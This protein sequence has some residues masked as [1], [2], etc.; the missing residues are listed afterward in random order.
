MFRLTN[1]TVLNFNQLHALVFRLHFQPSLTLTRFIVQ[2]CSIN[3]YQSL[4]EEICQQWGESDDDDDEG[5]GDVTVTF[6]MS[7]CG[8]GCKHKEGKKM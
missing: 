7:S 4:T 3:S 2:S 8:M 5:T 1:H 6:E